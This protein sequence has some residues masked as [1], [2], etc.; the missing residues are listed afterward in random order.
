MVLILENEGTQRCA[1]E[2]STVE[3]FTQ[4]QFSDLVNESFMR[5]S[6]YYIAR[7]ICSA[8]TDRKKD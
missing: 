6:D 7:L 3:A 1:L 5:Q 2:G 8:D 4:K